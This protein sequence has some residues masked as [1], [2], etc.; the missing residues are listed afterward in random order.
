MDLSPQSAR[1]SRRIHCLAAALLAG[2]SACSAQAPPPPAAPG[3]A[4][5]AKSPP[6]GAATGEEPTFSVRELPCATAHPAAPQITAKARWEKQARFGANDDRP[7]EPDRVRVEIDFQGGD[8]ETP[9]SVGPGRIDEVA[10]DN[11]ALVLGATFHGFFG[12]GI[13]LVPQEFDATFRAN[14]F[15]AEGMQLTVEFPQPAPLPAAIARLAGRVPLQVPRKRFSVTVTHAERL[16]ESTWPVAQAGNVSLTAARGANEMNQPSLAVICSN[17]ARII[18]VLRVLNESGQPVSGL[19]GP[20]PGLKNGGTR[21]YIPLSSVG[22]QPPPQFGLELELTTA[23]EKVEIPF[24]LENLRLGPPSTPIDEADAPAQWVA[25]HVASPLPA[26]RVFGGFEWNQRGVE[27]GDVPNVPQQFRL[28]LVGREVVTALGCG[29]IRFDAVKTDSGAPVEFK[30]SFMQDGVF[31]RLLPVEHSELLSDHPLDGA[32]YKFN[33]SKAEQ[34]VK[35]FDL[36][37][38]KVVLL[39]ADD[40]KTIRIPDPAQQA[41]GTLTYPELAE[42]GLQCSWQK[43]D[44][45]SYQFVVDEGNVRGVGG[46]AAVDELGRYHAL[47]LQWNDEAR[48]MR[49]EFPVEETGHHPRRVELEV[50]V[51]QNVKEVEIPFRFENVPLP[52]MPRAWRKETKEAGK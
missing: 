19:E 39:H 29:K 30:E 31:E 33:V 4:A 41:E 26:V 45:D 6:G 15:L 23:F 40:T 18:N 43:G 24:R 12:S 46:F 9:A 22:D 37:E 44:D 51:Y 5:A 38:G 11:G 48:A 49:I 10:V 3:G 50:D 17:D 34:P 21:Y 7:V 13:N 35:K 32:L 36:V 14:L 25:S 47:N 52:A 28:R 42:Q 8:A 1:F 20:G 2:L 16:L 27:E